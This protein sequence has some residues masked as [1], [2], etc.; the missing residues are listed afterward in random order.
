MKRFILAS[1]LLT[2]PL[3]VPASAT[4]YTVTSAT[5]SAFTAVNP[6]NGQITAGVG[7]G[8]VTLRSAVI[9]ANQSGAGPHVINVPAGTYNLT[10]SNPVSPATT[11]TIGLSDLQVGSHLS[12][13]TIQG[14]GGTAKIVQQV[15]S[16]DVITTGFQADGITPAVVNL[17][18][19]H[20][21]ITGGTFTGVFVGADDGAGHVSNTIITNCNIHDNSNG[22]AVFGQGGAIQAITGNL[23]ISDTAFSN[24]TAT[25]AT[26]GQGG[27]IY[28]SIPNSSGQ[29]STGSLSITNCTFTSNSAAL[30]GGIGGGAI[31]AN[32][33][34]SGSSTSITGCTFTTNTTSAGSDGGALAIDGTRTTD[35]LRNTFVSNSVTTTGHGGAIV[36]N[37]GPTNINF[38][39][40]SGNTAATAA[41]GNALHHS[42]SNASAVNANDN[43]WQSNTGPVSNTITGAAVTATTWLRFTHTASPATVSILSPDNATT[44]TASFLTNS[45]GAS[46]SLANLATVIGQPISFGSAVLGSISGAQTSIQSNGTATATYTAGSVPGAGSAGAT[47]NSATATASITVTAPDLTVAMSHSGN[48]IQGQTGKTYTITASNAG[49]AASGGLVTATISLPAGLTPTALTGAGWTIAPSFLSATRSDALAASESYPSLTLT[50][51]VAANATSPLL[52]STTVSG[53]GEVNL[54]NDTSTD[55]TIV[56]STDA[57]LS[58]LAA[59]IGSLSP[60]FASSTTDYILLV[61]A[62]TPSITLTPTVFQ[63]NATVKVN[64]SS[65]TSGSASGPITI[66]VGDTV[67]P[68]VVTAQD[69]VTQKTY[70]ITAKT[71][72]ALASFTYDASTGDLV[73]TGT[74]MTTGDSIA[75]SK[76][77]LVGE[78][79]T[80]YTLTSADVTASSN[81][82]FTVTLNGTDRSALGLVLNKNGTSSTG[83]TSYLVSAADDWDAS[84]TSGDTSD[85]SNPLTVFN[86]PVPGITS[87]TYDASSGSLTVT[88]NAFSVTAGSNNDIVASKLTLTGEGGSTYT[89]TDTPNVDVTSTT[90]F[91]LALSASDKAAVNQILNKAGTSSTGGTTYNLAAAEDW[92]AGAD[93]AV[94]TADLTGNGVT[95]SNVPAPTITSATYNVGTGALTVTGTGFVKLSGASND[96]DLGK[97]NLTGDSSSYTLTSSSVEITS[98]TSFSA[99]LNA[100][101]I[102]ALATRL[103]KNGTSSFNGVTY[104]LAAAEDWA[105]GADAAVTVADLTGN[106]ITV[107]SAVAPQV[108]LGITVTDG[109]ASATPGGSVTYTITA[110][111]PSGINLTGVT[112]ADTFPAILTGVAWT[113]T[114]AGGGVPTAS[115]SGNINDTVSLPGGASVTYTVTATISPAATGSL[116]NTATVTVP[117]SVTDPV[118][119]NNSAT[120]TDTLTPSANLAITKTDG[121]TN[122]T[123]GGSVTYI[124]TASNAGPSNVTGATVADTLPATITSASWTAVGTGGGTA[125]ASGSGNINDTVNLPAGGTVTY[126]VTASISAAATGSLSNTAT[127]SSAVADP[128]PANNSATDTD[129]IVQSADL[130]ITKTDG[131]TSV[132]AGGSVTYT[133]TASNAGPSNVTGVTIADS[134][135]ASI[136][137]ANWTGVGTGGGTGPASGSGNIND[138]SINLPAGGSFTFTVTAQ[139]SAAATGTLANTAT[140]AAPGGVTDPVPANNSA[141]DTDTIVQSADLAITKTDG[142]TSVTAGGSLTYTITATNAGPSNITGATLADTLPASLT[143]TWTAVGEGGGTAPASGSGN[144]NASVNIPVGGTVTFTVNASLS[145]TA[146][147]SLSNTA[148]ISVPGSATDPTPGNNSATDTDT[149]LLSADLAITK[150]DGVTA[151]NA[152]GSVTYTI[153]AS[154][155]GP[156]SV[157]GVTVADVLPAVIS[158]ATWTGSGTGGGTGPAS[159]S[160]NINASNINLPAGGSFTF[161][162]T[163]PVSAAATGTMSNTATVSAPGGV[164]DPNPGNNSATDSDTITRTA[165]LSITKTDGVT[166]ATPGGSVTYTITASNAGPSNITGATLADTLPASLTGTWT[167]VG[168]GGGTAPASGSGNINAS[169]N[170]PVGGSVTF[171]VSATISPAATGSLSNTAT[172]AVPV[173]ATDPTPGNN[174]ATDTDTLVPNADLAI[175]KTDGIAN[176]IPGSLVTYT[177]TATNAGPS[178]VPSATVADTLPASL[179]GVAWT[180]VGAGG[181]TATASGSGNINDTV[182]LPAGASVTY[183]VTATIS[184][185]ATGSL[186]NTASVSSSVTDPTPANNNATDT[187]TLTPSA[188][189]ALTITDS[190]DPVYAA[191]NLT[192]TIDLTN[193]GPSDAASPSVSL[194]LPAGT[195]FVSASGPAGWS[196][197]TPVVGANGTVGFTAAQLAA[198]GTA[199]FTVIGKVDLAIVNDSTLTATATAASS[200]TDPNPGNNSATTTTLAKS[201]ADLQIALTDSPDPVIAGTELT[202]VLELT[203]NGPLDADNVTVTDTLPAGTTFVSLVAPTGWTATTPA[204]GSSGSISITRPL[205]VNSGSNLFVL[206]VKVGSDV[207]N[208]TVLGNTAAVT[209]STVDP[210]PS[211]NSATATSSVE[212]RADLAVGITATP[213]T[214]PKG[215]N[216]SYSITLT[217]NGP[218]KAHSPVVSL[219]VPSQ[220]TFVSATTAAGWTATTPAVGGTGTVK[221]SSS[222]LNPGA[223]VTF[224]VVAKVNSGAPNGT[225]LNG[226]ATA[227]ADDVDPVPA[228][229]SATATSAVGTTSPTP[230]QVG[231]TGTLNTQNGLFEL[232]VKV[233]NTTPLPI[234]GFRL[235]VDYSAYKSAYPSLRLYNASS[236]ANASDVYVDYPFPVAVDK[237]VSM[238]LSFYTS[239]RTFPSPFKPKLVVGILTTSQVTDTNGAGVQPRLV[240]LSNK[241]VM[242]EFPSVIGHWYRVRFSRDLVNW[243]DCPVPIQAGTTRMQ[244]I[245][246]GPP[247]TDVPPS[248]AKSRFYIVNEINAP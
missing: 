246:S 199:S 63:A 64:G 53:G 159:G 153:T 94:V 245:D 188:D 243:Q 203:N 216:V 12:T 140:V 47:V 207:A 198:G 189:L 80:T 20:L 82:S 192:Y 139:V 152:G 165:D 115:G 51:D 3:A 26:K 14:T 75:V 175:T 36:A 179:T 78:G 193:N 73:A 24:N 67:I 166:N 214:A 183:T 162:V 234:N 65:V 104:N 134:L 231:T 105:S 178:N 212:T 232:T 112:V 173:G 242:L 195:T 222:S 39:R 148:T 113:A 138:S 86:V 31:Y 210:A 230:L 158:G 170:L 8:S 223:T 46:V 169:V 52:P 197:S 16:S 9:A 218:S 119:A 127:V 100:T 137:G 98:G 221:F 101:D 160:G 88:G 200:A 118:P 187:D 11:A 77:T 213:A 123:A 161:T 84:F 215:T 54:A 174:S 17:T 85:A 201:G 111:N 44:I 25:H 109:V 7:V 191:G 224:K 34:G 172:I 132:T 145:G 125:T 124:I 96:I 1:L 238:K 182:S 164:T 22:D 55:S 120:D 61:P 136:S 180:A 72:P 58:N 181:G 241:N 129:T 2:G 147:G 35:I 21:E 220:M 48:F 237:V 168:A 208:G 23:T 233:T 171:T 122:A 89:L 202:Y 99:T 30:A 236:P 37:N 154:N 41:N 128:S 194:P 103:N 205:F 227:T 157:T 74:G 167:A 163:A 117:G 190:P 49:N 142:V 4:T 19:D 110:S 131:V 40:F 240:R 135:P 217:N 247:F 176:A 209:S 69:G 57:R 185:S 56:L 32:V 226:T 79:G 42:V 70:T 83:G 206:V 43:W 60:V 229:N 186:S 204:V 106:G 121:V 196:A 156:S 116:S 219:P 87:A 107:S 5:D 45:A 235:H 76:L 97:F 126:T 59:S 130:S 144:I 18:L 177:I 33:A 184:P 15:A 62:G 27:A 102:A 114:G 95:V 248:Q 29:G 155:A 211:N 151:V 244:W 50:V 81:T 71:P 91:T 92:A 13:V 225:V 149:I 146:T 6:A 28:Y 141:T 108:D 66:G 133:I 68:T 143:G 239:T 150:T 93:S 10:D 90:A 38:N 228:N